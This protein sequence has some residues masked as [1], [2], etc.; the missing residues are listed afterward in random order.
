MASGKI[1]E[2]ALNQKLR[3][4]KSQVQE[5]IREIVQGTMSFKNRQ[6]YRKQTVH[7]TGPLVHIFP[8]ALVIQI[9]V[10]LQI[11]MVLFSHALIIH[12]VSYKDIISLLCV[13]TLDQSFDSYVNQ[14]DSY[15]PGWNFQRQDFEILNSGHNPQNLT[16]SI[17]SSRGCPFKYFC[18]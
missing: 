16:W 14:H 12:S 17:D 3:T 5:D 10:D 2:C 6:G 18:D 8:L 7:I 15:I 13:H 9:L 1:E 4:C 11:P